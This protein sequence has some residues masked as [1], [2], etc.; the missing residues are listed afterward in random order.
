MRGRIHFSYSSVQ[1]LPGTLL[2]AV[3]GAVLVLDREGRVR[4][5]NQAWRKFALANAPLPQMLLEGC[6]LPDRL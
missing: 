3:P 2:N 6:Q 5:V 4:A 1:L